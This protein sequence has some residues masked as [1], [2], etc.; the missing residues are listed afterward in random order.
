MPKYRVLSEAGSK[1]AVSVDGTRYYLDPGREYDSRNKQD[2]LLIERFPGRF[3]QVG[4]V[5]QATAEP[6]EKRT[7]RGK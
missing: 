2:K 4:K 1:I 7:V 3:Q 6:G 5:E